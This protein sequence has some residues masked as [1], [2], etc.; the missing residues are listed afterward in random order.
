MDKAHA[1]NLTANCRFHT[2]GFLW[3]RGRLKREFYVFRRPVL[4]SLRYGRLK[5][6]VRA[7]SADNR[8]SFNSFFYSSSS[9]VKSTLQGGIILEWV[10]NQNI[11]CKKR[12]SENRKPVFR[13]PIFR[14]P[15][16]SNLFCPISALMLPILPRNPPLCFGFLHGCIRRAMCRGNRTGRCSASA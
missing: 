12:S 5:P 10:C 1:T 6:V 15:V 3:V 13:F 4:H 8:E 14:R 11:V 7:L 9:W 16:S 2:C